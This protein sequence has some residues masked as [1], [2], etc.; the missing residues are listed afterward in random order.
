[1]CRS[2]TAALPFLVLLLPF[3]HQASCSSSADSGSHRRSLSCFQCSW[4]AEQAVT[5]DR[6]EELARHW[7]EAYKHSEGA[8][9]NPFK[10]PLLGV[11]TFSEMPTRSQ[12][13]VHCDNCSKPDGKCARW[14]FYGNTGQPVNVTWMCVNSLETGCFVEHMASHFDKETA[15]TGDHKQRDRAMAPVIKPAN[16][17]VGISPPPEDFLS[18]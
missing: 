10:E 13:M 6:H 5:R 14:T 8:I 3:L 2:N 15:R 12:L 11:E 1:M 4:L 9:D 17:D 18:F 16:A 7:K